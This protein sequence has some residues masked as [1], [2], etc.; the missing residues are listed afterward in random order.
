MAPNIIFVTGG[1]SGIGY[2]TVKALLE[3]EKLYQII[4]GSRSVESGRAAIESLQK[5]VP[6]S[7]STVELIEIDVTSDESIEKAFE[8]V[9]SK[10]SKLDTLINN[11]GMKSFHLFT[12]PQLTLSRGNLRHCFS[13]RKGLAARLL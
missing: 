10:Y 11:A 3:S 8:H 2:E 1:N 13:W 6:K 12:G 5:E 9:K 7:I 4:L